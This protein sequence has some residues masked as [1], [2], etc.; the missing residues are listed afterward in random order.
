MAWCQELTILP[1]GLSFLSHLDVLHS[2]AIRMELE[3]SLLEV[4]LFNCWII[5]S[6]QFPSMECSSLLC[7]WNNLPLSSG[8][9]ASPSTYTWQQ[10]YIMLLEVLAFV[11]YVGALSQYPPTAVGD[12]VLLP[13]TSCDILI[14]SN[15]PWYRGPKAEVAVPCNLLDQL[16][17]PASSLRAAFQWVGDWSL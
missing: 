17:L 16:C 14:S 5:S 1:E 6:C 9:V 15:L 8:H 11:C 3:A 2:Q 7:C 13:F 12:T 10:G 4:S